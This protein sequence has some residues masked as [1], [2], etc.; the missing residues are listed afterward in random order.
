MPNS[1]IAVLGAGSWGSALA[2]LLARNNMLVRLWG[3]QDQHMN[4][5]I[6][7]RENSKHLPGF[8]FPQHLELCADIES[9]LTDIQDVLIVV[10]SHAFVPLLH[11]IKQHVQVAPR[12]L[13]GTKGIEPDSTQLLS[14]CVTDIFGAIPMGIISGPSF[15]KEV[16][17]ALPTAATVATNDQQLM[18]DC[19]RWFH[20][21]SFRIYGCS[22]LIGSQV[23]GVVK[24]VLAIAF[25]V[26][27]IRV[28]FTF[29]Q[30][31][32]Q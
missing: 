22:D 16:A 32:A 12:I 20:S 8:G 31:F 24:N 29:L 28:I 10:P 23:C 18:Q 30:T 2:L 4:N 13:W 27:L 19:L 7:M 11:L 14:Q 25:V 15:A 6:A 17:E 9:A 3:H 26:M 21:D 5:L 1:P